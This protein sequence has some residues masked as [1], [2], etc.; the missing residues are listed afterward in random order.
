MISAKVART[1]DEKMIPENAAVKKWK[2]ENNET[3][4][5]CWKK[6]K[7]IHKSAAGK[8]DEKMIKKWYAKMLLEK[9]DK[10]W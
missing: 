9:N 7:K 4:K 5:C 2:N 1:N 8:N 6:W 10:K 3:Q